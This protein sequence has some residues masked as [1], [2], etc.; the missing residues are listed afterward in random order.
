ML[1]LKLFHDSNRGHYNRSFSGPRLD[2]RRMAWGQ[3]VGHAFILLTWNNLNPSVDNQPHALYMWDK[4]TYTFPISM[5]ALLQVIPSRIWFKL[6]RV[7]KRDHGKGNFQRPSINISP[8]VLRRLNKSPLP[9]DDVLIW[10]HFSHYRPFVPV[11]S[12]QQTPVMRCIDVSFGIS[13]SKVWNK[14]SN[15][16]DMRRHHAHVTSL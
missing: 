3:Q 10:K 5:A 16:R 13:L 7:S 11:D 9:N 2:D 14:Q 8:E 12:S 15:H 4:I 1:G 6:I